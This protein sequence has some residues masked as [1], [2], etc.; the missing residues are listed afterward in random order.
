LGSLRRK[1][2]QPTREF[3]SSTVPHR[4]AKRGPSRELNPGPRPSDCKALRANHATR[5]HGLCRAEKNTATQINAR[6]PPA[7]FFFSCPPLL[8]SRRIRPHIHRINRRHPSLTLGPPFVTLSRQNSSL[9]SVLFLQLQCA[10]IVR[11]SRGSL[12]SI[13]W[14]DR[15][16]VRSWIAT[17]SM[18][19]RLIAFDF[20]PLQSGTIK[21]NAQKRR[22][23]LKMHSLLPSATMGIGSGDL[24][25]NPKLIYKFLEKLVQFKSS[26]L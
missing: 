7:F 21:N 5:P 19:A 17:G 18:K 2:G 23:R 9:R 22:I 4:A 11:D 8:R 24:L 1:K 6:A 15:E 16:R 25:P 3:P 10:S 12:R 26:R 14:Y 13:V 20:S